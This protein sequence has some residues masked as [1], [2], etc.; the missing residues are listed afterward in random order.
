MLLILLLQILWL[1]VVDACFLLPR[2]W[3]EFQPEM[4]LSV[5]SVAHWAQEYIFSSHVVQVM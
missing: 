2:K 5:L 1:P 4:V 3:V